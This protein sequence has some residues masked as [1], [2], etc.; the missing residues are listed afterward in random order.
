VTPVS[1]LAVAPPRP[2]LADLAA[3]RPALAELA[4]AALRAEA[5]LAPKPGLVDARG[6]GAH[7]DMDLDLLLRSVDVLGGWFA[8]IEGCAAGR[9]LDHRLMREVASLG[10]AAEAD[11]LDATG[12]VNTH[13]GALFTLGLLVA[14]VAATGSTTASGALG[15]AAAL[16][17]LHTPRGAAATHGDGARCLVPGAGAL[18]EARAG[19]PSVSQVALPALRRRARSGADLDPGGRP[20]E[21]ATRLD[22]LLALVATVDDTCLLHR[23]GRRGLA[24][25]QAGAA[26]VLAV[27][28]AG[29]AAGRAALA[30]FD[31]TLCRER[32]SPG[33]SADLLAAALF[34]EALEA[35]WTP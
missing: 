5:E 25:A 34:V 23:G 7:D 1:A 10:V 11:L 4:T 18:C 27:G 13:R 14:G 28:G 21:D 31:A 35:T 30:R 9:A 15:A 8:A 17:R 33:G 29:T 20:G 26:D 16:A 2:S 19:F 12:G 22:A 24:V 6:S 32:L 3:P